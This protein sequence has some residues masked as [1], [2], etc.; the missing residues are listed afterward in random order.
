MNK[1]TATIQ[2]AQAT[3]PSERKKKGLATRRNKQT[4]MKSPP[5]TISPPSD[6]G[7][8]R[9]PNPRSAIT[10]ERKTTTSAV[11]K[12][13]NNH[14]Q[15][16]TERGCSALISFNV[17]DQRPGAADAEYETRA[18]LP[19]SLDLICW[20]RNSWVVMFLASQAKE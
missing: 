11:S 16:T 15:Q 4:T 19:G 6:F 13:K 17:P 9:R 10:Q 3:Q 18:S 12:D 7:P 1:P 2:P 14:R 5:R 20:A 8:M